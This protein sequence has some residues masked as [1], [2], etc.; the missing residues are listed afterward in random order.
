[1]WPC[2]ISDVNLITRIRYFNQVFT[3]TTKPGYPLI[4]QNSVF[5]T[6]K[7]GFFGYEFQSE[8]LNNQ[9]SVAP[10]DAIIP[11]NGVG[12]LDFTHEHCRLYIHHPESTILPRTQC[13]I[14]YLL[15]VNT[16]EIRG[17]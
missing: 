13:K 15:Y 11:V 17:I 2:E 8:I 9:Q 16:I 4:F 1:V 3:E 14:G 6:S 7:L 5:S 10:S 12:S